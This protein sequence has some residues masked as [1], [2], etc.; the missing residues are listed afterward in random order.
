MTVTEVARRLSQEIYLVNRE[1]T[2]SEPR[3]AEEGLSIRTYLRE[4]SGKNND[5]ATDAD[6]HTKLYVVALREG[7]TVTTRSGSNAQA[8]SFV[9][10]S[11]VVTEPAI[12][13]ESIPSVTSLTIFESPS[14]GIVN[15]EGVAVGNVASRDTGC[16]R[17][18][19]TSGS[20]NPGVVPSLATNDM[21][22]TR[23]RTNKIQ[24]QEAPEQQQHPAQESPTSREVTMDVRQQV[25]MTYREHREGSNMVR[26]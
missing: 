2:T 4:D 1:D 23:S 20:Q 13:E 10:C 22:V 26:H 5:T 21:V 12:C 7:K 6:N 19:N 8:R 17:S 15:N 9:R 14:T 3:G 25:H 16:T 18:I 24:H 11:S